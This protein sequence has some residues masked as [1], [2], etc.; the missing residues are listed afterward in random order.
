MALEN[1][2][3][4][5][6]D[7]NLTQQQLA[8]R[9]FVSRQTIC[10]WENGSRCPDLITAKKLAAEFDVSLDELI[11]D[12]DAKEPKGN[13]RYWKSQKLA[14]RKK[15]QDYQ[16]GIFKFIETASEIFLLL[17]VFLRVQMDMP[18]PIWCTAIGI[19][20]AGGAFTMNH[21]IS[22]RMGNL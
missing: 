14:N 11:S 7:H 15:L 12:E 19:C 13:G 18:V 21:I 16:K 9:L 10:R 6:E 17:S 22:K 4:L 2:K 20:I 3:K 5:R 1:I 8:D